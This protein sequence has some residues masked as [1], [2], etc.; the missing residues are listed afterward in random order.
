MGPMHDHPYLICFKANPR[1]ALCT[2]LT[3]IASIS[4]STSVQRIFAGVG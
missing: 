4:A 3:L 2:I 1:P